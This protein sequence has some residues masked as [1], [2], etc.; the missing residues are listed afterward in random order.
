M[1]REAIPVLERLNQ[2]AILSVAR[3]VGF[4]ALAIA[5]AMVGFYGNPHALFKFGGLGFLLI[6]AVL[7]MKARSAPDLRYR[8]TEVWRM[9]EPDERPPEAYAQRMIAAALLRFAQATASV[10][11][12]LLGSATCVQ[13]MRFA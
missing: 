6:A 3:G 8:R 13:I 11:V 9:L 5:C 4:A 7:I 12:A 1:A 2:L 10:S